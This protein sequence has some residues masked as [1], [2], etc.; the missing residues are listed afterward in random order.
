MQKLF[1]VQLQLAFILLSQAPV[2]LC[3]PLSVRL[4]NAVELYHERG[5]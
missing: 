4:Y 3:P 1:Q 5:F 2:L